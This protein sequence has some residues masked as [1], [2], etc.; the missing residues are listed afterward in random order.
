[1]LGE[2]SPFAGTC[3]VLLS[4]S[5]GCWINMPANLENQQ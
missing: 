5:E 2:L 1:M 4:Y 3:T